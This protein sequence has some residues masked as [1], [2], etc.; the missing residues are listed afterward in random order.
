MWPHFHSPDI[1]GVS[2]YNTC[3]SKNKKKKALVSDRSQVNR[4]YMSDFVIDIP[5][6]T[7]QI[8]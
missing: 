1:G 6:A 4:S 5:E 8:L 7:G 2:I 3:T